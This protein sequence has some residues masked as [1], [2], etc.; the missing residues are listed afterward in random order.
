MGGRVP[1]LGARLVR[2]L[3]EAE[4]SERSKPTS[5]FGRPWRQLGSRHPP[6]KHP[7]PERPAHVSSHHS[8]FI[9]FLTSVAL[10]WPTTVVG[11]YELIGS[12]TNS[13]NSTHQSL[14][15][16]STVADIRNQQSIL[17]DVPTTRWQVM[18]TKQL[19]RR[20]YRCI[21]WCWGYPGTYPL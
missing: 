3:S 17:V 2:V 20:R 1:W 14:S 7:I 8:I 19:S 4:R 9:C 18:A 6:H 5:H 15:T 21:G 12:S 16:W 10:D 13:L 11:A